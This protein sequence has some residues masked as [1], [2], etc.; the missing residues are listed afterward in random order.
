MDL[1]LVNVAV[2]V[3][4]DG[5]NPR[6]LNPDFLVN[7][8]I[9]SKDLK[10]KDVLVT[11][12]F[13]HVVYQ[14]GVHVQVEENKLQFSCSKPSSFEWRS[15]L[16][17]IASTYLTVLPHVAYRAV[18]LNFGFTSEGYVDKDLGRQLVA[19]LL[20]TGSWLNERG[21]ITGA[22]VQLQYRS[23]QPIMNVSVSVKQEVKTKL[24]RFIFDVNFHHDFAPNQNEERFAFIRTLEK[25]HD[26]FLTFVESLPMKQEEL[27]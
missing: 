11:P 17:R 9:V 10:V 16:T 26:E 5:N 14:E 1:E 19:M 7:N 8:Q 12:P 18:G 20:T 27:E 13:A 15:E 25:Q 4:S 6:L 23:S 2:V 3:V 22:T 24:E 21:G